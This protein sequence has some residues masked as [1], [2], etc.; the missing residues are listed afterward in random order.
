MHSSF[1]RTTTSTGRESLIVLDAL[2]LLVILLR[3]PGFRLYPSLMLIA[4]YGGHSA[5]R[6]RDRK[7]PPK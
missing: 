2:V 3:L 4:S 7:C 6:M 5:R 1:V